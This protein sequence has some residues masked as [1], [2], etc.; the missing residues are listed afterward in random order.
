VL[1]VLL[2]FVMHMQVSN[3]YELSSGSGPF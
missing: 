3:G 1:K 2:C